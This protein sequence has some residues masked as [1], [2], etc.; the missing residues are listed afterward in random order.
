MTWN[1]RAPQSAEKANPPMLDSPA[2][3]KTIT[4]AEDVKPDVIPAAMPN[5][6]TMTAALTASRTHKGAA[7]NSEEG[8]GA[9]DG[10]AL[11]RWTS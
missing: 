1:K 5:I 2:A 10:F 9:S 7:A 3:A 6:M 11:S 4:T 8:F